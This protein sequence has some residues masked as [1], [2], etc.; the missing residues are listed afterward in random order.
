[1]R[2]LL[3]MVS[4]SVMLG[5]NTNKDNNSFIVLDYDEYKSDFKDS[6]WVPTETIFNPTYDTIGYLFDRNKSQWG[7]KPIYK[8]R[9]YR[10]IMNTNDGAIY[11]MPKSHF[12]LIG[13]YIYDTLSYKFNDD[14]PSW[15][16]S[17]R[18]EKKVLVD[19]II[20]ANRT[21]INNDTEW[22]LIVKPI[23]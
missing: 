15:T 12:V 21:P 7:I 4:I 14:L 11:R 10:Y 18:N 23:N 1:M 20:R 17:N 2:V 6:G 13:D 22:E 9:D 19:S 5:C 3:L 8:I 16:H